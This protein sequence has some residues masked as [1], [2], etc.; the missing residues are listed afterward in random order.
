MDPNVRQC[1]MMVSRKNQHHVIHGALCRQVDIGNQCIDF[2]RTVVISNRMRCFLF[3]TTWPAP[4]VKMYFTSLMSLCSILNTLS[5]TVGLI[6]ET[7]KRTFQ[8]ES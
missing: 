4:L 6:P 5:K 1:C 3:K 2:L 7:N 8:Y